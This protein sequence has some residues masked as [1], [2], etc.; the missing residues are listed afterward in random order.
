MFRMPVKR[1]LLV[2]GPCVFSLLLVCLCAAT[3]AAQDGRITGTVRNASKAAVAGATVTAVNQVTTRRST[4]RTNSDG[5]FSFKLRAG[6]YRILVSAPETQIFDRE[7][8][9]VEPGKDATVEVELKTAA[10]MPKVADPTE[11][12]EPAGYAGSPIESAPPTNPGRRELRDRWRISFPEYDRYGD[13]GARGRD[14]PARRG[15]WYNPYDLNLLKGDYPIFG[16]KTFMILSG[17][18]TVVVQ[19][20][21]T[22]IPSNVS[23]ARPG[24]AEFFGKPEVSGR[25]PHHAVHVRDVQR[26]LDLPPAHVGDQNLAHV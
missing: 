17:V 9:I 2:A 21:R 1:R 13:N 24:S 19:Q 8:V 15:N 23:S 25:E 11:G 6:A 5:T 22:P 12:E 16:Q 26:R 18:D 4:K 20:Q 7:N 10:A 14:I 3:A